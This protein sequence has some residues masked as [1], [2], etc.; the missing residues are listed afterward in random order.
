MPNGMIKIIWFT[1]KWVAT[2][3]A[4]VALIVTLLFLYDYLGPHRWG[5]PWWLGLI[6][7]A[8]SLV[9]LFLRVEASWL[10]QEIIERDA[11]SSRR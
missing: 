3:I 1:A 10:L 9:A 6:L 8:T 5:Y 4:S 11:L 2:L 7:L